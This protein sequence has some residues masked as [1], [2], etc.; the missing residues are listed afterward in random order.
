M[1]RLGDENRKMLLELA[2]E[3]NDVEELRRL[4]EI[5]VDAYKRVEDLYER[6]EM[7]MKEATCQTS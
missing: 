1:S 4:I 2:R 5:A 3:T 6:A 7:A